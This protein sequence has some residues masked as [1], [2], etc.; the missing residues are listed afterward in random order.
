MEKKNLKRLDTSHIERSSYLAEIQVSYKSKQ[1]NKIV[2]SNSEKAFEVLFPLYDKDTIEYI[3]QFYLIL[4]NKANRILGWINLSKGGTGGT[5]IDVKVIYAIAL[6]AN[7]SGLVVSH[8]H[9]SGN[10]NPSEHDKK[11]TKTII[12]AGLLFNIVLLDHIIVSHEKM[13]YSFKD[14]GVLL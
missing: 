12:K 1:K 13:Y 11:I 3:E 2:I 7:A 6:K 8:N 9:P 10:L 14:E 4:L 5:I